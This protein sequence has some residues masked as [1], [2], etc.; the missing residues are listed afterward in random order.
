MKK[1]TPL[2]FTCLLSASAATQADPIRPMLSIGYD[3]G[4]EKIGTA[5]FYD[6]DDEDLSANEGVHVSAGIS[7]PLANGLDLQSTLGYQY[8]S[9]EG[10]NGEISWS[11]VPWE[12]TLMAHIGS[13]SIGGGSIYQINPKF[14]SKGALADLGDFDFDNAMGFQA[15]IAWTPQHRVRGGEYSLGLR[16]SSIEFEVDEAIAEKLDGNST[17]IYLKYMF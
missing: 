17:A 2:L 1:L 5:F 11:S 13:I 4:G 6:G 16:Y 3:F 9:V 12:T 8:G 15:Q 14:K 7:I 10:S